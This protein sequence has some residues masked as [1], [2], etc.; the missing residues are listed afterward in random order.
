MMPIEY[1]IISEAST[2][3]TYKKAK[4]NC[5]NV[6]EGKCDKSTSCQHYL[7]AEEIIAQ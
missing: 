5:H 7:A 1:E 6:R 2:K 3:K 4:C